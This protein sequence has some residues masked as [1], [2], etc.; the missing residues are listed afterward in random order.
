MPYQEI[1]ILGEFFK[2]THV[3]NPAA[4]FSLGFNS[5]IVNRIFFSVFAFLMIFVVLYMLKISKSICERVSFSLIIGGAIGN[6]I[7]RLILGSVTDFFDFYFFNIF[8]WERWPT[9][10]IADSSIVVAVV[11]LLYYTIFLEPKSKNIES[12]EI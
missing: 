3:Q 11:I 2:L 4:A 5:P 10:N 1:P 7:D 12:A 9:F 8:G 6:L